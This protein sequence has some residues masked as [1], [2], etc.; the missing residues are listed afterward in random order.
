M[1][2]FDDRYLCSKE[3]AGKEV[4]LA[5]QHLQEMLTV[6]KAWK[7]MCL[8]MNWRGVLR[9]INILSYFLESQCQM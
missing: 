2:L 7:C 5:M 3:E 6:C 8:R 9:K 4:I 1:N